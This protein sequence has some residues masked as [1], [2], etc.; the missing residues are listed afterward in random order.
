[1]AEQVDTGGIVM[2][3]KD[4][5]GFFEY[6]NHK[7]ELYK[8]VRESR[9]SD[10]NIRPYKAANT[11]RKRGYDSRSDFL[12]IGELI[13]KEDSDFDNNRLYHYSDEDDEW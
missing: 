2:A 6:S 4:N 13:R 5:G 8:A 3:K 7:F 10:G 9:D 12:Q 1:M 11:A